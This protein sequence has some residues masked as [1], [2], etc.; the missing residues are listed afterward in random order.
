MQTVEELASKAPLNL[1]V[2]PIP[3][4][5]ILV[6]AAYGAGTAGT[7][8]GVVI[9]AMMRKRRAKKAVPAETPEPTTA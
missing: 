1:T 7:Q 3:T 5:V 9:T 6:L 8:A 4:A 2:G